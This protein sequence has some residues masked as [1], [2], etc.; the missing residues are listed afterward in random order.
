MSGPMPNRLSIAT[1]FPNTAM[2]STPAVTSPLHV[3]GFFIDSFGASG[4][5]YLTLLLAQVQLH[6]AMKYDPG[7]FIARCTPG[8]LFMR[9]VVVDLTSSRAG[10]GMA[11]SQGES[12][13]LIQ[14]KK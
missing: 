2:P 8:F 3:R 9:S 7:L 1:Q 4:N 10:R 12:W 11:K 14:Q 13:L 5:I 6:Q